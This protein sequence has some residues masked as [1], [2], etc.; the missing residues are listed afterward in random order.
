[1]R[2]RMIIGLGIAGVFLA[3]CVPATADSITLTSSNQD[4]TFT[5]LGSANP[6]QIQVT[7]GDCDASG[8]TLSGTFAGT[9]MFAQGGT[10]T[11]LTPEPFLLACGTLCDPTIIIHFDGITITITFPNFSFKIK[12]TGLELE[13]V[14]SINLNGFVPTQGSLADLFGTTNSVSGR[15]AVVP[16]PASM[17]LF[18]SGL[19]SMWG[20]IRRKR[21][22]II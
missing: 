4:V 12:R 20:M 16:E 1:M 8:C 7:M 19:L 22:D 18:G 6:T 13:G 10:Y 15:F 17:L 5:G 3:S 2:N 9:G 14:D 21:K 11:L